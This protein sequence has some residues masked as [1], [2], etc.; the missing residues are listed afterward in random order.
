MIFENQTISQINVWL[1][2]KDLVTSG[3]FLE[4]VAEAEQ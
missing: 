3:S 2:L 1:T 4:A